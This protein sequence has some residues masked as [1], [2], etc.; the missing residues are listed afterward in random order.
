M[1]ETTKKKRYLLFLFL[2]SAVLL[3]GILAIKIK[4]PHLLQ[5]NVIENKLLNRDNEK[6][7]GVYY[8]GRPVPFD[9][10]AG[11]THLVITLNNNDDYDLNE[12]LLREVPINQNIL[13]T[14]ELW[15]DKHQF[16]IK[17]NP[18]DEIQVGLYDQ[19]L[20][21]IAQ[22]LSE[23]DR[24][25]F[26]RINP[27]MEVPANKY[28]WQSSGL[29]IGAYRYLVFRLKE[30]NPKL[31]FVWGPSGYMGAEE[32]YPGDDVVDAI[33]VTLKSESERM[34]KRTPDYLDLKDEIHRKLHRL[35]FFHKPVILLGTPKAND[36]Q[37]VTDLVNAEVDSIAKYRSI[38]YTD[39]LWVNAGAVKQ[40][41]KL[42]FGLYDPKQLL[43]S[44][45][46][47]TLEHIFVDFGHIQSGEFKQSLEDIFSRDHD[48]IVTVEPWRNLSGIP[49]PFVLENIVAG[50]YDS[51]IQSVFADVSNKKHTVYLRF[52]HEMEIP[53]TRYAWQSR[54]PITYIKAYRYFMNFSPSIA[55]NVKRVWGPAGDRASLD[56]YPG[57][58]VVDYV[59]FAI[60]GLPDKNITDPEKQLSFEKI[61]NMKVRRFSLINK[62]FFIT[63]FGVKG[64]EDYQTK[65]L[66][67]AAITLNNNQ[68]TIGVNYF[69]MSDTP[70][71]WGE[72]KA[73]DWSITPNSLNRFIEVLDRDR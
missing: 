25:I 41:K 22:T 20:Q 64:P 34:Y 55:S 45:P 73:P 15:G 59:S 36:R 68:Q 17:N 38:A 13:L 54:D 23:V 67:E 50:K 43:L 9:T 37:M 5:V 48:A 28:P 21:R 27:E 19:K 72:M 57:D 32:F 61:F 69:N 10:T 2:A 26:V 6:V 53:I 16:L 29:N 14:L 51:T 40:N 1:L 47:V 52:A 63:E 60:Y 4:K 58:D 46:A 66:E 33:S 56:F 39:S 42:I 70:G 35:R 3:T 31:R 62:P 30:E 12:Q 71:A 7:V 24:N 65:W 18:I 49:D 11:F 44:N 8:E